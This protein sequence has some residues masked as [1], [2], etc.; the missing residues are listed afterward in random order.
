ML[1]LIRISNGFDVRRW[2]WSMIWKGWWIAAI[3][4]LEGI[5]SW[6]VSSRWWQSPRKVISPVTYVLPDKKLRYLSTRHSA[7]TSLPYCERTSV[8]GNLTLTCKFPSMVALWPSAWIRRIRSKWNKDEFITNDDL[9]IREEKKKVD[10]WIKEYGLRYFS[11][12]TNMAIL[13][14]E[15]GELAS[16]MSRRYGDQ[17]WK[18]SDPLVLNNLKQVIEVEWHIFCG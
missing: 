16:V 1:T 18:A 8:V 13:T 3:W 5:S 4:R 14:E 7:S 12:L 11:E 9:T 6:S 2:V 10:A 15:I 17:L